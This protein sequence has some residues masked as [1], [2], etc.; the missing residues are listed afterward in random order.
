MKIF[1]ETGK[2]RR[3]IISNS[4]K[5]YNK[6]HSWMINKIKRAF[7]VAKTFWAK[8]FFSNQRVVVT[9]LINE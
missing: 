8:V 3:Q 6:A 1:S 4:L 9:G 2:L 5:I 7:E